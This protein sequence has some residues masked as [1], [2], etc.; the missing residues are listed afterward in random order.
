MRSGGNRP[1]L[2]DDE[3]ESVPFD[4]TARCADDSLRDA[5]AAR[6][7]TC[8]SA[9]RLRVLAVGH[10]YML[11]VNQQKWV[12]LAKS[13]PVDVG[14]LA[15][16]TWPVPVWGRTFRFEKPEPPLTGFGAST[17]MTGRVGAHLYSP[18]RIAGII[19]RFQPDL[20]Q[21]EQESFSLASFEVAAAARLL[22][23][24]LSVFCW[25]NVDRPLSRL[26]KRARRFVFDSAG[27]MMAGGETTAQTL[28]Q[29]GYEGNVAVIPQLG[30]EQGR[31]RSARAAD[32]SAPLRVGF[33]GRLVRAKGVDI[34][35]RAA[36][37]LLQR[38]VPLE[39]FVCGAG[40]EREALERVAEDLGVQ[41]RIHWKGGVPHERVPEFLDGVDVLVLPSR[42]VEGWREQFGHVLLEAM[43]KAI[44]VVGSACGEIP[45]VIGR[46]D[47]VFPEDDCDALCG[48][49]S[50]LVSDRR[51]YEGAAAY[52]FSRVRSMF[53]HE[54]IAERC[55][56]AWLDAFP[57]LAR[58]LHN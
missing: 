7:H 50:R 57:D 17:L 16:N 32:L 48:I 56:T 52:C 8:L 33:V 40:P 18:L 11:R 10:T 39:V 14:L 34:L 5:G 30:V 1:C 31:L 29:W 36:S 21:M 37:A 12:A 44:P 4:L 15:P 3:S 6:A 19:R 28:R 42:G 38:G 9:G 25:E 22:G 43:T 27:L 41:C 13:Y 2:V 26:R 51:F 58:R 49:L 35:I 23:V 20:I 24:P 45:N 54:K 53:T 46:Q 47:L 55:W